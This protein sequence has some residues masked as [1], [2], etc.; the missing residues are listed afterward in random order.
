MKKANWTGQIVTSALFV[1]FSSCPVLMAE[2][3]RLEQAQ[4]AAFAFLGTRNVP[5]WRGPRALSVP[6]ERD[7]S[8]TATDKTTYTGLT[9][10]GFREIRSDDGTILAYVAELSPRG[11]V[12]TSADT[13]IT[14]I[15][16]YSFRSSFP[17]EQDRKN[18]LCRL[19][20]EDMKQRLS[21]VSRDPGHGTRAEN[22]NLWNFYVHEDTGQSA[23]YREVVSVSDTFQQW[24][25]KNTTPTGGWLETA[26]HQR[27]PY[28]N[29]CPLDP[30]DSKRSYVGCVATAMA[31]LAN[32]HQQCNIH[33]DERY[34]YITYGGINIDSD[35][36]RYDFPSFEELNKYLAALRVKYSR[37]TEP[38]NTDAAALSFACGIATLTD[39]SSEG[40]GASPFDLQEALLDKFGFYSA[41]MTGGLSGEFYHVLQENIINQ[42]PAVLGIS[43]P[44]GFGGHALICDGY[45]TNGEY[46]LNFGWGSATPS[47]ITEAWYHLPSDLPSYCSVVAETILN[48]QPVLPSIDIEPATFVFYSVPGQQSEPKKLLIKNNSTQPILINSI[49]SPQGFVVSRLDAGY[50]DHIDSFQLG[51]PQ[52]PTSIYVKFC[53][54]KV[55]GYYGILT[56]NFASD[57]RKYVILKG[58]SFT[59]GT[60]IAGGNVSGTW[61]EP[62]SPYFV[63]GDI[64]VPR[65]SELIIE[66]GVRVIFAGP[67]GMTI[68][69]NARLVAQGNENQPIEFTALN[70]EM[71]WTGL[72]FLDSGDDDIL[73]HCSITFAKKNVGLITASDNLA[74][75]QDEDSCGGAVYC[76]FSSPAITNCKITNNIADKGGAI[77]CVES[78]SVISN[79]IIANNASMGGRPRCG[80]ICSDKWGVLEIRNCTIVNNLPGGIFTTSWDGMDVT[81]TIVWGNDNYQIQTFESTPNVSFCDVQDG[82]PGMGNIDADPCFF[83]AS[84]GVGPEYDGLS[85]NWT[86]RSCS[87]CINS[88]EKIDLPPTDLAGSPRIYSDIVDIG[89]YENQSDLPL[90][91]I[92]PSATVDAGFVQLNTDSTVGFDITN[93]GKIDFKIENLSISAANR[94]SA[95]REP[96]SVFSIVTPI[97]DHLL[98]PGSSVH[99]EIRFTPIQE[100]VYTGTVHVYSTSSNAPHKPVTLHGVGISGTVV[101]AGP[102]SGTWTQANSPYAIT[103]DI[104]VPNRRRLTIEPGVVVKFA[105]HF[106]LTVG[107]RA[108]LQAIGT[109]QDHIVITSMDTN[110]GW[111]GIRFV[112]SG[113]DDILKY[114]TIEYSKKPSTQ[115]G[116]YLNLLGGAILCCGSWQE[117]PSYP[118][119]SSPTIDHCIITNNQAETA[120]GI[121]CMDGSEAVITNNT[122]VRNSAD[123]DVG[124]ILTFDSSVTIANNVIAHNS[125]FVAG[126]ILNLLSAVS[127]INNTIVHNRPNAL[128]L[129]TTT[130]SPWALKAS[131]PILNNIIWQNEIYVSKLV[132]PSEYDIRFNDI[133]GGWAGEGNIDVDPLFADPGN[134]DYHL[135]SQ[136]G[137]WDPKSQTWVQDDVTSPCIDAGDP[138]SAVGDEPQPNGQRIN[139]GAFGGTPQASMSPTPR[140]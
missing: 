127:I 76:A 43:P 67:Y 111:F 99:A 94:E 69:E 70:R 31:Q 132:L 40:S 23:G 28:N 59:G 86:L 137:R 5:L 125:G 30:V 37:Q 54:D 74:E 106:G 135:K 60:E 63:L 24:P 52:E 109:E 130:W 108:T 15:V 17:P 102:V 10:A 116:G 25:Q 90:I 75:D 66:P 136:A 34:S 82:Y 4:K 62:N 71:G 77:Y 21:L 121:M 105:G 13:D 131:L 91:T 55:G 72:R 124:G 87:P 114:C 81:N 129:E 50:S 49:D 138:A 73:S 36:S 2:P 16:A 133:Q 140:P 139:M 134:R 112:N 33:F 39:Y 42:L 96:N 126:G 100:R 6:V 11:F 27:P 122:I 29:F 104:R 118:V 32:Y 110:E 9:L 47:E 98:A 18:P 38:N 115:G 107:H 64:K 44:D 35:S 14:P 85:S 12:A 53:P 92:T 3:V 117:E 51:R 88:G 97:V 56:I 65:N 89:A 45:N 22:N 79:T 80:G 58:C 20:K 46:H 41:E 119:P 113:D 120:G 103:G 7:L 101:P 128:Y 1:L 95:S 78:Y 93:T 68:G 57:K 61:S 123:M 26:W 84:S 83:G 48:V 8:I 19:L